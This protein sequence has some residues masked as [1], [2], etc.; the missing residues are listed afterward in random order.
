[1]EITEK[2]LTVALA[3][4]IADE[5]VRMDVLGEFSTQLRLA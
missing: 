4:K 5:A 1:V 3:L 2:A